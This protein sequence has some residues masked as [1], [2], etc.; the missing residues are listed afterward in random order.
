MFIKLKWLGVYMNSISWGVLYRRWG[1]GDVWQALFRNHPNG[2]SNLMEYSAIFLKRARVDT[3]TTILLFTHIYINP[4]TTST[5]TITFF[6]QLYCFCLYS[7]VVSCLLC[8]LPLSS[9]LPAY[10]PLNNTRLFLR[11]SRALSTS[12]RQNIILFHLWR[13][14]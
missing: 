5:T 7:F 3:T 11:S 10:W 9:F 6:L 2:R 1:Q 4:P 12:Y 8:L 13:Y 14:L